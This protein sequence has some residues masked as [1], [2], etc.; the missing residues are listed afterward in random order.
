MLVLLALRKDRIKFALKQY[1]PDSNHR[2][3]PFSTGRKEK[4]NGSYTDK[5]VKQGFTE[6]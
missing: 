4:F 3:L 6:F 5:E 2:L 1:Q